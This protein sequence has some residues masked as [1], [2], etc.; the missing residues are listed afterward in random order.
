MIRIRWFLFFVLAA[1]LPACRT[2]NIVTSYLSPA[3]TSTRTRAP[4]AV[5][6][7]PL[8]I[9]QPTSPPT[10]PPPP[11]VPPE[12]SGTVTE[13]A[14][15]RSAPSTSGSIVARLNKGDQVKVVG[16]NDASSWYQIPLPTDVNARG[17]VSADLIQLQGSPDSL[18][19]VQPGST[20]PGLT[21]PPGIIPPSA[22][23]TPRPYP[24]P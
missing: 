6:T 13:N 24:Y 18:P 3:P 12:L 7:R 8:E 5:I 14:R 20:P 15:V 9:A 1:S 10:L 4:T 21:N 22:P 2:T 19:V 23:P 16:R 17:W 11:T